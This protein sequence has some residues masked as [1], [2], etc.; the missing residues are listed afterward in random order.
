MT[1]E[2]SGIFVTLLG[3]GVG[4]FLLFQLMFIQP[5]KRTQREELKYGYDAVISGAISVELA[6]NWV[7]KPRWE[8]TQRQYYRCIGMLEAL[9]ELK[10]K[11]DAEQEEQRLDALLGGVGGR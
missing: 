3:I 1:S 7:A 6:K 4:L 9:N 10:A 8:L 5:E 2:A 11:A